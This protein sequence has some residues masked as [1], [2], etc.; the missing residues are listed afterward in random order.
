MAM[1]T[2]M[3]LKGKVVTGDAMF[4][5]RDLCKQLTDAEGDYL[6]AVK[7]NQPDLKAAIQADFPPAT[8]AKRQ[9]LL[10][11][12]REIAK[13]HGRIETRTIQGDCATLGNLGH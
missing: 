6:F 5:Q 11:T 12:H 13:A 2:R 7:D 10:E 4:C 8:E 9:Q 3:L 1:L